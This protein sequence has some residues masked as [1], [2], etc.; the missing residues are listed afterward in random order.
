MQDDEGDEGVSVRDD[1]AGTQKQFKTESSERSIPLHPCVLQLGFLNYV[2]KFKASERLFPEAF[3]H[4]QKAS[5]EIGDW[6]NGKLLK[7]TGLKREGVVLYSLR[8]TVINRFKADA[9]VDHYACAYTGHSTADDKAISNRIYR[10]KYGRA[11]SPTTFLS[12]T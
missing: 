2:R 6:L 5:R 8:H 4:N 11:F 9:T 7:D 12:E 10:E 1:Q 3:R